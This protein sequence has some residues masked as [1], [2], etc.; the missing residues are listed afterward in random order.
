MLAA[1]NNLRGGGWL[2]FAAGLMLSAC[3]L[4]AADST[5]KIGDTINFSDPSSRLTPPPRFDE[6]QDKPFDFLKGGGSSM[7]PVF[8]NPGATPGLSLPNGRRSLKQLEKADQERNWIFKDLKAS[9]NPDLKEM[10]GVE[11]T[12]IGKSRKP[13][14]AVEQYIDRMDK[15]SKSSRTNES[16]SDFLSKDDRNRDPYDIKLGNL[17][18]MDSKAKNPLGKWI[19]PSAKNGILTDES[20]P[21]ALDKVGAFST[22]NDLFNPNV[23]AAESRKSRAEM[24]AKMQ[25]FQKL[26]QPS[27]GNLN[28][29]ASLNTGLP[30][31]FGPSTLGASGLGSESSGSFRL[32][33]T[34]GG[35]SKA[36]GNLIISEMSGA[37]LG[38]SDGAFKS[39]F[40]SGSFA[41][42]FS[43]PAPVR[44]DLESGY[45]R[46][47]PNILPFQNALP[48]RKF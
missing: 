19:D 40:G 8:Q 47:V 44:T 25:D 18:G 28:S 33:D 5:N 13:K 7:N 48:A 11:D 37:K 22:M 4:H 29:S 38:G 30:G 31:A 20:D 24:D 23:N 1:N 35:G 14:R 21:G 12:S 32:G 16:P 17:G 6:G 2:V 3:L 45:A 10:M 46:P 27:S 26:L 9:P 42:P 15:E 41:S 39:S 43:T 36:G 34:L